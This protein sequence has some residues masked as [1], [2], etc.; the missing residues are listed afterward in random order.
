MSLA[1]TCQTWYHDHRWDPAFAYLRVISRACF[2]LIQAF[3]SLTHCRNRF[4]T[5][6]GAIKSG[7]VLMDAPFLIISLKSHPTRDENQ[8]LSTRHDLLHA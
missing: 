3:H 1:I 8:Q 7:I 6:P 4:R 2:Y 5:S